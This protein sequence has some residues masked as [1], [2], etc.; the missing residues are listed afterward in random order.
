MYT[1]S[2]GK[3]LPALG[4]SLMLG[5]CTGLSGPDTQT[6]AVPQDNPSLQNPRISPAAQRQPVRAG[7]WQQFGDATLTGLVDQALKAHPDISSARAS[8]QA[9]RAQGVIADAGLLPSLSGSGSARRS[10]GSNSF[11]AGMDASWE[12]D[13]FGANRLA[14]RSAALDVGSAEAGLEDAKASLAAE[15]ARNY[16]N[17]RLSQARLAN[18]HQ[19]LESRQQSRQLVDMRY[20]AGLVSQ[21]DVEQARLSVNQIQA[22][23]PALDAGITQSRQALATLTVQPVASLAPRLQQSRG[24]PAP[25]RTLAEQVPADA[26][27]QRP[28]L[29]AAGY[30]LQSAALRVQE[31]KANQYPSFRLGGALNLSSAKLSDLV[32]TGNLARSLL[33]SISAPLFDGGQLKQQV[34]IRDASY[35]QALAGYQKA[36]LQAV[37]D[38]ADSFASLESLRRQRPLLVENLKLARSTERLIQLNYQAGRDNYQSVLDAQRSVTSAQESLLAAQA[39]ESLAMISLYRAVGGAW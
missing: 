9:A 24:I 19:N 4:I 35:Q 17:L 26:L 25:R 20:Q 39:D 14:S 23:I 16:V 11:S 15:V 8:L 13:F 29:R 30:R 34:L 32:D 18:A 6:P 28:D 33:A 36:L 1:A 38:V 22:Q 5:A 7:W 31:A 27:R 21:L 2:T 12:L 3:L 37:Q 10:S